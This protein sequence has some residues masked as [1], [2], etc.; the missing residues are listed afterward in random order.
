MLHAL[1]ERGAL[2]RKVFLGGTV[3]VGIGYGA[4]VLFET[5]GSPPP[6]GSFLHLTGRQLTGKLAL[7]PYTVVYASALLLAYQRWGMAGRLS[8]LAAA[9]RMALSN[10]LLASVVFSIIYNGYG[11]ELHG[12][13]GLPM[14]FVIGSLFFAAEAEW[15]RWWLSRFHFGPA[16]WLWRTLTYGQAQPLRIVQPAPAALGV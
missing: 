11:L 4:Q 8:F 16:E 13:V 3:A 12:T 9:G 2:V 15:S 5:Y 10:Y 14:A 7:W 6:G 1:V